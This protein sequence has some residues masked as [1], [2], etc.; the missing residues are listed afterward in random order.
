MI[1]GLRLGAQQ[2]DLPFHPAITTASVV[3][4]SL[5]C[6]ELPSVKA[7]GIYNELSGVH[8]CVF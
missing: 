1:Q 8:G 5:N 7:I 2:R 4:E 6:L 3:L